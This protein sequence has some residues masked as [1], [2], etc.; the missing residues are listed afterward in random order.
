M[1]VKKQRRE[2]VIRVGVLQAVRGVECCVPVSAVY[3]H[4]HRD[5]YN[6]PISQNVVSRAPV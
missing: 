4:R 2:V 5:K 1:I 6:L 3:R